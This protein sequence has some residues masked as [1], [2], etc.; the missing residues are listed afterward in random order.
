MPAYGSPEAAAE[1]RERVMEVERQVQKDN[2]RV[3]LG[4]EEGREVL[5]RILEEC[6]IYRPVADMIGEGKRRVGL[7]LLE[8]VFTA[9]DE[10]YTI[11][12]KEAVARDKS[13]RQQIEG[14]LHGEEE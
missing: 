7:W 14:Q 11:L 10:A 6:G 4:T 5:W 2:M 8:E 12:R 1:A 3:L 9:D 13:R